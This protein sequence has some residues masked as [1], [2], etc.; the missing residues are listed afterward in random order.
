MAKEVI[1]NYIEDSLQALAFWVGYQHQVY[2]H[3]D[4]PEGA[5]V[6]EL[7]RLIDGKIK[8]GTHIHLEKMYRELDENGEWKI[9]ERV[10][11]ALIKDKHVL[12][13]IE[14]KK[15]SFSR[16]IIEK[17]IA[18]LSE[19]KKKNPNVLTF[20]VVVSQA[21]RPKDWINE[22]GNVIGK[23]VQTSDGHQYK[24]IRALKSAHSFMSIKKANFCCLIEVK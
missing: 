13:M 20:V 9:K 14:V 11:I 10:D 4:L 5:I 24:P 15:A 8:N 6:A 17:D 3:H 22:K 23:V 18:A 2:R 21:K 12:A 16:K 1:Q 19:F 7:A